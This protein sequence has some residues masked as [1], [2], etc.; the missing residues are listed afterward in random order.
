MSD[1]SSIPPDHIRLDHFLKLCGAVDTGGQAKQ[2]IQNGE[3]QVNGAVEK[4]RRRKLV[5]GDSVV[6]DEE[7]YVIESTDD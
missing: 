5:A 2:L 3:V 4:R 7:E 1:D 6:I